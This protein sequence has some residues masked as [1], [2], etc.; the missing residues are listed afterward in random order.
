MR[1]IEPL[2]DRILVEREEAEEVT[3]GGLFIPETAKEPPQLGVVVAVGPGRREGS[4]IVPMSLKV[5]DRVMFGKYSGAEFTLDRK[6]YL[7]MRE[8]EIIGK[9]REEE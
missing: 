1:T 7:I 4:E 3:A 6:P 8:D 2:W 5:G 9:V